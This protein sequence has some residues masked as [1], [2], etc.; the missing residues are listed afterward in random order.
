MDRCTPGVSN[1]IISLLY[2][3]E[4]F[5]YGKSFPGNLEYDFE[6]IF[7]RRPKG[8]KSAFINF[9]CQNKAMKIPGWVWPSCPVK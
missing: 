3:R 8:K 2:P 4:L 7:I 9:M 5:H 1:H 6:G